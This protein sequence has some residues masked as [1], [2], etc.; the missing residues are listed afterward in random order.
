MFVFFHGYTQDT[1]DGMIKN[2]LVGKNDGIRFCQSIII[3]DK[4]KFNNLAGK[5]SRL[6]NIVREMKCPFYID[7]LQGGIYIDDYR[8]DT[9]LLDEYQKITDGK[10]YGFQMHEWLS[11]YHNDVHV[12]LKELGDDEWTAENIKAMVE[13]KYKMPYLFLE[14]M[15]PEEM[16]A[17]GKPKNVEEFYRKMTSIFKKR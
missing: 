13:R 11:N 7:R 10:F 2:G 8:Y 9:A 1:W 16:A 15:T 17:S 3:D 6:Y 14:S 12:K 5:G 4:N